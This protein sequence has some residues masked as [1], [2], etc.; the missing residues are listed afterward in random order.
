MVI[1]ETQK[2][3]INAFKMKNRYKEYGIISSKLTKQ[4]VFL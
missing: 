4:E 1:P 3:I 2:N